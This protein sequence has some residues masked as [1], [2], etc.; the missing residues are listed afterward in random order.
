MHVGPE[1]T[2]APYQ[3]VRG[4]GKRGFPQGL[5]W[6]PLFAILCLPFAGM[7]SIPLTRLSEGG[8]KE[9]YFPNWTGFADDGLYS[10]D[11]PRNFG[12]TVRGRIAFKEHRLKMATKPGAVGWP[13]RD[14]I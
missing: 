11:L 4:T 9:T 5:N 2:V 7:T 12:P 14:G 10:G 13:K 1:G 8:V 6:S 3:L